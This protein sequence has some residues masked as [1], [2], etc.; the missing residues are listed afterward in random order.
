MT[1]GVIDR[2]P[3]QNLEAEMALLGSVL[4]DR[5]MMATVSEIVQ[6]SD[7]YAAM[8]ETIYTALFS[9]YERGEPLDKVTL[10]E[11][12]KRRNQLE[13]VGGLAYLTSLMDTVPTAASAEYYAH[14][15]REKATLRGLIHAGT[16][17]TAIGYE[18]EEDVEEALDRCEQIV[19]E[20]G[21]RQA[22]GGFTQVSQMLKP[23][24][25]NLDRLFSQHGD[26]IGITSGF[27]DIDDHTAGFQPGNLI[28]LAARPGMGKTSLALTMAAEGARID[29]KPIAIFSLEMTNEELVQRLLSSTAKLDSQKLKRGN[30]RDNEWTTL[31]EAMSQLSALPLYLDDSGAVTV[32]EIRSRCRRLQAHDGLGAVIIDYLQLVRPAHLS[33]GA[34]RNEELSEICRT[35]KATAK[36]LR[37]PIIALSQLNRAVETRQDKRPMLS[38]LRESGAI[39]QEADIVAFLYRDEYYNK[40]TADPGVTEFIL[41]KHRNGRTGTIKLLFQPEYTKFVAYAD[42]G[43]YA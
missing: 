30:I 4:V 14:I 22:R 25:D 32:T 18:G 27:R 8:H 35:L 43:R 10:S 5:E 41:A 20:V 9:L 16:Q 11:E 33:R 13:K 38:D 21:K 2:I 15:V 26:R 29:L 28:V 3:P 39:E 31:S 37:V 34:N 24:F 6:P 17:V 42:P 7:F 1:A 12:L 40:E 36:D 19:Y 23:V